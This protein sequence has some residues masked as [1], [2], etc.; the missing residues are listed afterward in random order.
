MHILARGRGAAALGHQGP[1]VGIREHVDPRRL[2]HL[3]HRCRDR[4]GT[5]TQ[6]KALALNAPRYTAG[7]ANPPGTLYTVESIGDAATA[8]SKLSSKTLDVTY[9][10]PYVSH[11]CM[12]VLNCTVDYVPGERCDI[13]APM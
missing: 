12:E 9:T 1:E 4:A 10:L 11:A 6:G 5:C 8:L 2:R 3:L 13:H 7:G